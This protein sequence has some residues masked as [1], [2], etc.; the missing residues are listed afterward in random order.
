MYVTPILFLFQTHSLSAALRPD[1]VDS[2]AEAKGTVFQ[3][4]ICNIY[5]KSVYR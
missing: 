1:E 4:F 5:F 3:L 2:D